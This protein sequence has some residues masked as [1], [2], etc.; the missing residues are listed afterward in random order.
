MAITSAGIGSGL[1]VNSLVNQLVAAERAPAANRLDRS[2]SRTQTT[3]SA[4]GIFKSVLSGF[5]SAVNALKGSGSSLGALSATSS[6]PEL[7]T[8]SAGASAAPGSYGVEVINLAQAHKLATGAYASSAAVVGN[9]TVTIGVGADSFTVTLDDSGNTLADLRD[10]INQASDNAGVSATIINEAGGSRLLLTSRETGAAES[11]TLSSATTPLLPLP[12]LPILPQGSPFVITSEVQPALDASFRID[13][14]DFSSGSNSVSDAIDGVS[15]TLL[16]A[17]P[18]TLASLNIA[19]DSAASTGAVE[20]FVKAYN[21]VVATVFTYSRY[22]AVAKS[23]GPLLGDSNARSASQQLRSIL[24]SG[25]S[26]GT[27]TLLVELGITTQKDGT[28]KLDSGKL[29][30]ALATDRDGVK[31]LFAGSDGYATRLSTVL[32]GFV[33]SSGRIESQSKSL[34]T[35][36]DDI[37]DQRDAL[38]LRSAAVARRYRTQFTALDTLLGQLS[39]TSNFLSQQ[40]GSLPGSSSN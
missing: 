29:A 17:E 28:L 34:Q 2:Q 22:D 1:D 35:R 5:Q 32:D 33:G 4:I 31:N 13:G 18:G 36:L 39:T 11:L 26:G 25:A 37:G 15:F 10:R 16:K 21:A 23:G 19:N 12:P 6:K 27:F 20:N 3:L 8:A 40:L 24:G 38:D 30:A 7:F 14:F 9:G